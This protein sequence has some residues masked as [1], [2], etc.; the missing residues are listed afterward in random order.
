M[1]LGRCP[2]SIFCSRGTP[3]VEPTNP[4]AYHFV[5]VGWGE[6]R[7]LK[8]LGAGVYGFCIWGL[9]ILYEGW[10]MCTYRLVGGFSAGKSAV[11]SL[12]QRGAVSFSFVLNDQVCLGSGD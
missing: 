1:T 5:F 12:S 7:R 11:P 6:G 10:G 9:D 8:D 4:G 2:L 3:P